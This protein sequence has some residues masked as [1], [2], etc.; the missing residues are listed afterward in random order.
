MA[1]G[2][3]SHEKG[4]LTTYEKKEVGSKGMRNMTKVGSSPPYGRA[5]SYST[6]VAEACCEEDEDSVKD[7]EFR[8][9]N[10]K[11]RGVI[12]TPLGRRMTNTHTR[13]DEEMRRVEARVEEFGPIS[14]R[15]GR[16]S[17]RRSRYA[18]QRTKL[19]RWPAADGGRRRTD[20]ALV[21]ARSEEFGPV[22]GRVGRRSKRRSRSAGHRTKLQ[23]PAAMTADC[24]GADCGINSIKTLLSEKQSVGDIRGGLPTEAQRHRA[25]HRRPVAGGQQRQP[26]G[27]QGTYSDTIFGCKSSFSDH[28]PIHQIGGHLVFLPL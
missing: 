6:P 20:L 3:R 10:R 7:R 2:R 28:C 24:S 23:R 4:R 1:E 22:F 16:R 27:D 18:G 11:R 12:P 5:G 8:R 15:F 19:G 21:A 9:V 14:G 13:S 26:V 17:R 25:G